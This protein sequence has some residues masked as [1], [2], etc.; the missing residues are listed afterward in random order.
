MVPVDQVV[1]R[2]LG[3]LT[4]DR[5]R[6]IELAAALDA[7]KITAEDLSMLRDYIRDMADDPRR[8][9]R[10]FA[11][12]VIEPERLVWRLEDVRDYRKANP[13]PADRVAPLPAPGTADRQKGIASMRAFDA[14]YDEAAKKGGVT[15]RDPAKDPFPWER[16]S[17]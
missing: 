17:S 14:A 13:P 10:M 9:Q 7:L 16:G 12:L 4:L 3:V 2:D 1:L 8:A 11:A 15:P 5:P 6:R